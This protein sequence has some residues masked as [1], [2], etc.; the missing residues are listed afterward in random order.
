MPEQN[1]D[2]VS[3]NGH[4][5]LNASFR[6]A[7]YLLE[8]SDE[9]AAIL[10][11]MR[12]G[13]ELLGAIGCAFIPLNEWEQSLPALKYGDTN[14]LKDS[15]WQARLSMPV[16]RHTCRVCES[17]QAGSDCILLQNQ[18]DVQNI[19]CIGLRCG[20]RE[21]GIISY[22]FH[23]SPQV[24]SDQ[25]LFL[26]EMVRLT[27]LA[28]NTLR[29][30]AQQMET[31]SRVSTPVDLEKKLASLDAG[32]R[33]LLEQLEYKAVLDERTRL[34]REIHDGLAQTLAFLKIEAARMQSCISKGEVD[35]VTTTL[36]ACYQTLS[37]A[38]LDARRKLSI[39]CRASR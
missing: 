25:H 22:F 33:E 15:G 4:H 1:A 34:A 8:A 38:Y 27:D 20:G 29:T 19:F 39:A 12:A 26:A 6:L 11:T 14:F 2:V 10:A 13:A 31:A 30:N 37:D 16:T 24:S 17:R 18:A 35:T 3:D 23:T 5:L 32:N 28:L 21:V 7:G 9:A 36:Q